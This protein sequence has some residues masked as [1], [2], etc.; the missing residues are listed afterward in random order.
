[1]KVAVIGSGISGLSSAYY[2]SKKYKVDLFEQNSQLGGHSYTYDIKEKEKIVPVDLGFIV[3]N[4]L[5]Y[6]NLIKFFNE[7][8]V[9]KRLGGTTAVVWRDSEPEWWGSAC[10]ANTEHLPHIMETQY[11]S[12]HPSEWSWAG[13]SFDKQINNDSTLEELRQHT[14]KHLL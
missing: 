2:L 4:E 11:P 10:K 3:F 1:M 7:L 13:W 6:S 5:T 14:L 9:I 8:N 12:V